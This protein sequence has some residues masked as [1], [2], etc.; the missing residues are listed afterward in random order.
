MVK[1]IPGILILLSATQTSGQQP[2]RASTATHPDTLSFSLR[3]ADP[4]PGDTI[5]LHPSSP[6]TLTR[7]FNKNLRGIYRDTTPI[8]G[9]VLI[10][11]F[12]DSNGNYTGS[13]YEETSAPPDLI[14]EIIRV[15]NRLSQVPMI[16]TTVAGKF[17][18][19]AVHAK[20]IFKMASDKSEP[21]PTADIVVWLY[22]T[23]IDHKILMQQKTTISAN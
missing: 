14:W 5:Y 12:A 3:T 19:S 23:I 13:C 9:T 4:H 17:F 6:A 21:D 2:T 11:F 20:L 18:A 16:P 8:L 10:S 1:C 7:F 15:T 22:E